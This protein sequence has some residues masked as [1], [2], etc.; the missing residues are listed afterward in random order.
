MSVRSDLDLL[1]AAELV[2]P[3]P[4]SLD[5]EYEFCHALVHEAA[6]QEI[7]NED[8]AVLH[9][10]VGEAMERLH[11]DRVDEVSAELAFHFRLGGEREKAVTYLMRSADLAAQGF[12]N[13]EALAALEE[14]LEL[15]GEADVR[16]DEI[17]EREGDIF[18]LTG[19]HQEA[20]DAFQEAAGRAT[21]ILDRARLER[22]SGSCFPMGP[23]FDTTFGHLRRAA[24]LLGPEPFGDPAPWWSEW[25]EVRIQ[26]AYSLYFISYVSPER[27]RE[28]IALLD[29]SREP[30]ERW[31]TAR[32]RARYW[33]DC[34]GA[35]RFLLDA[36]RPSDAMLQ[37]AHD[38]IDAADA[39]GD[40][41]LIGHSRFV[42]G[43]YLLTRS[44]LDEAGPVLA[45]AA[46][47]TDEIGDAEWSCR[48]L[49]YLAIT[50]R[51]LGDV[52][53]VRDA[54]ARVEPLVEHPGF[55]LY[56][57]AAIANR[58]WL[59]RR[60]GETADAQRGFDE[61]LQT[62]AETKLSYPF[63][64]LAAMPALAIALEDGDIETAVDHA[65]TMA[66]A[67]S[68]TLTDEIEEHL[69]AAVEAWGEGRP[70]DARRA[71]EHGLDRAKEG[72]FL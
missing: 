51:R 38:G 45:E 36:M 9:R 57:G 32:Q 67:P 59:E 15:V 10:A 47:L 33:I 40:A 18:L 54:S 27:R 30:L 39:S 37:I 2:R 72:G 64:W 65:E 55:G 26:R 44:E 3:V 48:S 50:A 17:H 49:I 58:A 25:I 5:P 46:R 1:A 66:D 20:R 19:R 31:G 35:S 8:R 71:L 6:Y 29:E 16:A 13:D 14:A 43:L 12:A 62:W 53:V 70:D 22:K 28:L 21:A 34:V 60:S 24:D 7:L 63:A 23:D 42:L 61:A 69:R 52:E 4:Q 68:H 11:A 41:R 56:R